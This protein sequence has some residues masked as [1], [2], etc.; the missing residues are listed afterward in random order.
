MP[1]TEVMRSTHCKYGHPRTEESSYVRKRGERVYLECRTCIQEALG[2]IEVRREKARERKAANPEKWAAS[3]ARS[4]KKHRAKT[5]HQN[6]IRQIGRLGCTPE[7][8]AKLLLEQCGVCKI[9]GKSQ[10][11]NLAV[12][13]CH[14][15]GEIRGLL[16]STCNTGLGCFGDDKEMLTKALEY[17]CRGR[18]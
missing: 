11:R 14:K 16:C 8:Y 13:H 9:C 2:P 1:Y 12:D 6:W 4:Y 3:R 10:S 7:L 15:T 18:A 5:L 17:L